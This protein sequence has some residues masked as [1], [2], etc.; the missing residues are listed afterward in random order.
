M[1]M[2]DLPKSSG[3]MLAVSGFTSGLQAIESIGNIQKSEQNQAIKLEEAQRTR[4]EYEDSSH[5][6]Q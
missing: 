6:T 1:D 4:A 5:K 3:P 2:S